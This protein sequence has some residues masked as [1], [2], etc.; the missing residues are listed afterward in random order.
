[1]A[2]GAA[3][4][5][6]T[7]KAAAAKGA[8]SRP[9]ATLAA[10]NGGNVDLLVGI[11]RGQS[12]QATDLEVHRGGDGRIT[13]RRSNAQREH[14]NEGEAKARL[15]HGIRRVVGAVRGDGDSLPKRPAAHNAEILRPPTRGGWRQEFAA[16]WSGPLLSRSPSLR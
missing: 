6:P 10:A 1:M 15:S 14:G 4:M 12:R 7:G 3:V 11:F 9:T 13:T 5:T 8:A 16:M 2:T